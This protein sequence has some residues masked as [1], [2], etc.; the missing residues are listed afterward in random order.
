MATA[1][2]PIAILTGGFAAAQP[3]LDLGILL[4]FYAQTAYSQA[5]DPPDSDYTG[6][7]TASL[8]S[9]SLD[10]TA[11]QTLLAVLNDWRGPS[12]RRA[13]E[14][15]FAVATAR[16]VPKGPRRPATHRGRASPPPRPLNLKRT[17]RPTSSL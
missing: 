15:D 8:S 9:L 16:N 2:N 13:V 4:A 12:R 11:L 1:G 3:D 7:P 6:I 10:P 14:D 5:A 17:P